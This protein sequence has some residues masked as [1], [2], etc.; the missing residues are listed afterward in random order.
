MKNRVLAIL[1]ALALVVTCIV[2][3]AAPAYAANSAPAQASTV[4]VNSVISSEPGA[5]V[6]WSCSGNNNGFEI[7]AAKDNNFTDGVQSWTT[8][9]NATTYKIQNKWLENNRY[10]YVRVKAIGE[11]AW[12]N[13]VRSERPLQTTTS[14]LTDRNVGSKIV[15]ENSVLYNG[16]LKING[17]RYYFENGRHVAERKLM[18]DGVKNAKSKTKYLVITHCKY[19]WTYVYTGRQGNWRIYKRF[20]CTTGADR[21]PTPKVNRYK[22]GGNKFKFGGYNATR[23]RKP[24]TC[25]FASRFQGSCFYH[26]VLYWRNSRTHVMSPKL[27]VSKSHGCIRLD[28][29]DAWWMY[30]N[31][32]KGTRIITFS[33]KIPRAK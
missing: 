31:I 24:Y 16:E 8:G 22:P 7:Q 25:W 23:K 12:S 11:N 21:T 20:R 33:N 32:K 6:N 4:K 10:Y 28:I 2:P 14:D 9:K 17:Q 19:N 30:K 15:Y 1:T 3:V 26:S 29:D 18:W 13:A 5:I 27:G